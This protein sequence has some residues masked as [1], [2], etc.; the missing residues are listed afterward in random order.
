MVSKMMMKFEQSQKKS[1]VY[2]L[3]IYDDITKEKFDWSS[4]TM[5]K[6]ETSAAYVA[7]QLEQIPDNAEIHLFINSNGGEVAEA[8]AI[9]NQLKRHRAKKIGY[10]DGNAYSAASLILQSCD[11]RIMGLGSG[12]LVHEMWV[13]VSGNAAMLRSM[14]DTLD[15]LMTA[16]RKIYMERATISEKELVELMAEEKILTP[17]EAVQYGF[18]DE[19]SESISD[20]EKPEDEEPEDEDS[21]NDDPE[22]NP[23]DDEKNEKI[24][25]MQQYI[26]LKKSLMKAID[27]T[28][29]DAT[30]QKCVDFFNKF[31]D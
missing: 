30:T 17:E 4:W 18:A 25:S 28:K 8:T 29:K 14:A 3:F 16:N 20:E 2:N 1:N 15:S 11:T 24:N 12:M 13:S 23:S 7:E 27:N 22:E 19:I 10:V 31:L 5:V 21:E 6:S 9:Y 26:R